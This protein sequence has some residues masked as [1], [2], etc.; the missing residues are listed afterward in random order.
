MAMSSI[1]RKEYLTEV[2]RLYKKAKTKKEKGELI[3]NVVDITGMHRK[4]VIRLLHNKP[5]RH[6]KKP[7]P[8]VIYDEVF[9]AALLVCW[10]TVND[11][12]AERLQPFLPELVA[13]L[14]DI[15]ELEIADDTRYLLTNVSI[16]TVRRH[17]SRAKRR[18]VVPLGT[19][20]PGNLLKSQI[21]ISL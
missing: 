14:E 20:K 9:H 6:V 5:T 1:S 8:I 4:A 18:S 19:T 12:C 21:A 17:L 15:G 11:I 7:G 13:K 3:S 16:S 10:H 2:R